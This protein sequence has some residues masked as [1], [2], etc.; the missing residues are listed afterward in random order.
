MSRFENA[1]FPM[2][3]MYSPIYI[4]I[5]FPILTTNLQSVAEPWKLEVLSSYKLNTYAIDRLIIIKSLIINGQLQ[6]WI[7]LVIA[8]PAIIITIYGLNYCLKK[9]DKDNG[10]IGKAKKTGRISLDMAH[11]IDYVIYILLSQGTSIIQLMA[12][13][14]FFFPTV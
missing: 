1:D 12:E 11:S 2:P 3:W 8:I 6:V 4:I 5:P 14:K 10:S 13:R 9:I 7:G